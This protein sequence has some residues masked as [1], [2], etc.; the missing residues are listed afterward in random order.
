MVITN[1]KELEKVAAY[2]KEAA[3][4]LSDHTMSA[5]FTNVGFVLEQ[6]LEKFEED[7]SHPDLTLQIVKQTN[8]MDVAVSECCTTDCAAYR[9]GVCTYF[10]SDKNKC[11]VIA[12]H[13]EEI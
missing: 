13:L 12:Q 5:A 7:A 10:L 3:G 9:K 11:P 1:K 8:A 2:L 6:A 4:S